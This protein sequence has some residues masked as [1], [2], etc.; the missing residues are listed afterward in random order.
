MIA[1]P[2]SL[3]LHEVI[4]HHNNY[5]K[6]TF[7][8]WLLRLLLTN[9]VYNGCLVLALIVTLLTTNSNDSL[10]IVFLG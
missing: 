9:A 5:W 6:P 7:L 4:G 2:V 8:E 10:E 1:A 3:H